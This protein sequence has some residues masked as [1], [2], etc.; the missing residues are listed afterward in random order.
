MLTGLISTFLSV[1]NPIDASILA[2]LILEISGEISHTKKPYSFF[3][4]LMDNISEISDEE[5]I[6][7]AKI[8]EENL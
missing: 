4:N 7:R 3:V 5:I 6:K 8:R 1:S 2:L